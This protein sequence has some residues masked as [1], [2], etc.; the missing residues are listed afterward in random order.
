MQTLFPVESIYP[1][2]FSYFPDFLS[3]QEEDELQ[4]A[5]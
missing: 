2:G 5:I 3:I 1:E 4:A